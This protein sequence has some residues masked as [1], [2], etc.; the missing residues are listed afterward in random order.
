MRKAVK[1]DNALEKRRDGIVLKIE[2]E[3]THTGSIRGVVYQQT[4]LYRGIQELTSDIS[5]LLFRNSTG[6]VEGQ[7]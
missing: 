1:R 6:F 5:M 2:V 4:G 7:L 3:H